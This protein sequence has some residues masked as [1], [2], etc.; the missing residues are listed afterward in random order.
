MPWT[1]DDAARHKKGLTAVQRKRWAATAN[2]VLKDC[3]AKK[4]KDCEARAIRV[5]SS[6]TKTRYE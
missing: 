3:L 5:A 4:G 2:A 6:Q 1:A